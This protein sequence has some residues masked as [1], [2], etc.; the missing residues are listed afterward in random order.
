MPFRK[1]PFPPEQHLLALRLSI[2]L[3]GVFAFFFSYFFVQTEKIILFFQITG[4]IFSGGAGAVLIGGLYTRWGSTWGAWAALITGSVMAT[5]G[6]VLQQLWATAIAPPLMEIYPEWEYL[7]ENISRFPLNGQEVFFCSILG[8]I[9]MYI[10]FSLLERRLRKLPAFPLERLLH[11]GKYAVAEADEEA[12]IRHRHPRWMRL[13]GVTDEFSRGDLFIFWLTMLWTFGWFAVVVVISVLNAFL[14]DADWIAFWKFKLIL[15][16]I[17]G[18]L[19]TIWFLWG[20]IRDCRRLF[21]NLGAIRP[22]ERDDG[23]VD[24]TD[25]E[26]GGTNQ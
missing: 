3:V 17:L 26:R 2:V 21:R 15:S 20:G 4:A 5:G 7:Q 18:I 14:T 6:I 1:K 11:R 24:S 23:W 10:L 9:S 22:D 13:F 12:E 8:G 16:F 19:T 25:K